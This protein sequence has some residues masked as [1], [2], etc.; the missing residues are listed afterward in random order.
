MQTLEKLFQN[1]VEQI[2]R[3]RRRKKHENFLW[4]SISEL[5]SEIIDDVLVGHRLGR[6]PIKRLIHKAK[7]IKKYSRRLRRLKNENN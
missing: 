7:L 3:N 6:I 1:F 5:R 2:K 4:R